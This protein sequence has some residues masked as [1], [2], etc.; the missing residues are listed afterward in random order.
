VTPRRRKYTSRRHRNRSVIVFESE[1]AST[2]GTGARTATALRTT[3][4]RRTDPAQPPDAQL[5]SGA[6]RA[7]F[8][9]RAGLRMR[10]HQRP[11]PA[12]Q[13]IRTFVSEAFFERTRRLT[14][15]GVR[16][17]CS[18]PTA[19][20]N[21]LHGRMGFNN[22]WRNNR[23]LDQRNAAASAGRD[24]S[25]QIHVVPNL[26]GDTQGTLHT[27]VNRDNA[28]KFR[29][30]DPPELK[31]GFPPLRGK[32]EVGDCFR[33]QFFPITASPARGEEFMTNFSRRWM[34]AHVSRATV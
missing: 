12:V 1:T 26:A 34:R 23:T 13:K 6:M 9:G 30:L 31:K 29:R 5:E 7:L 14:R 28:S 15:L 16:N 32:L 21:Y 19:T 25:R 18:R 4:R 10:P 22:E 27:E 33:G 20:R 3:R 2:N 17:S 8:Q 24:A 11:R